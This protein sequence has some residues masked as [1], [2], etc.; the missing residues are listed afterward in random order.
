MTFSAEQRHRLFDERMVHQTAL[1]EVADELVEA[2]LRP[3][4]LYPGNAVVRVAEYTHFAIQIGVG[5]ACHAGA[6]LAKRLEALIVKLG[7]RQRRLR[8]NA[9]EAHQARLTLRP[10]RLPV[11]RDMHRERQR[12]IARMIGG[13]A[14]AVD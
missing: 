6:H 3:Q 11:R 4:F 13:Q 9:Q 5:H 12:G 14:L 7:C 8:G 1:V 10:R 2:I